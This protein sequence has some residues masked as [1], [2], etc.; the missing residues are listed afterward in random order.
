MMELEL[1]ELREH[2]LNRVFS[3]EG[4]AWAEFVRS[5]EVHGV[6]QPLVVRPYEGDWEILAGH[7]RAAAAEECGLKTVPCTVRDLSDKE[8]VEFLL[9]ENLQREDLDVVAEAELVQAMLNHGTDAKEVARRISRSVEWVLLRQGVLLLGD[10]VR[11]ALKMPRGE[12]GH[13]SV[14]AAAAL[15]A[16]P[17]EAREEAVQMVLHPDWQ[18]EPLN[19]RDAEATVKTRVL[20]P[21]KRKVAW[22]AG[23]AALKKAW[24]KRLALIL[25][26]EE[27]KDL[28]VVMGRWDEEQGGFDRAAEE[29]LP[30]EMVTDAGKGKY[31]AGLA[32]RHGLAVRVLP[33]GEAGV[34]VV[35]GRLLAQA[36][37]ARSESGMETWLVTGRKKGRDLQVVKAE[38]DLNKEPDPE[39]SDEEGAGPV[40]TPGNADGLK[41]TQG[42]EHGAWVDMGL[43]KKVAM[44]AISTDADPNTAPEWVPGWA[45]ELAY[46]GRWST[47]DAV[48]NWVK[49]LK[50]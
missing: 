4:G 9:L 10:E 50:R 25:T 49:S 38:A 44:W 3:T 17:A 18:D 1:D 39:F 8:A 48:M 42:M 20:E 31:W 6:V 5:V 28:A 27:G 12:Q 29:M 35:D 24:R 16:V 26:K 34:A 32:V 36:E 47:I 21:L 7:R 11:A 46:E 22:E 45:K 14:G 40:A 15:L 30:A 2:P 23:A 19:A 43:V 37:E 33:G 13:L 41:I